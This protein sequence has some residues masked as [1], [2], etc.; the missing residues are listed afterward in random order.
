MTAKWINLLIFFFLA[1]GLYAQYSS[2]SPM[3]EAVSNNAVVEDEVDGKMY[4]Y[5]FCGI[6]STKIW[7]GIH[8]KAW[9]LDVEANE[10]TQLPDVPDSNG[11]KIAAAASY[12]NGKIY[13]IGGYHVAQSGNEISSDKVHVFDP[14]TNAWMQDAASIPVPVDDHV[15]G[16][17]KDS[18]IYV[19]TGWSNSTNVVNVQIFNPINNSWSAG[20]PVPNQNDYRVF[21][22]SG[23][24]IGDT[25]YYAGGARTTIN[26]SPSSIFRKGAINPLNPNEIDW[27][28]ESASEAK[29]YRMASST[30]NDRAIWLGGSDITYNY[31]GIAYNG[32]GGVPPL[33]RITVYD[34]ASG[35]LF[36]NFGSMP[37]I[38][39]L[40][41]AAKINENEIVIAGGMA[42]NQK[43]TDEVWRIS[44]DNLTSTNPESI[45]PAEISVFPN[46]VSDHI[47]IE[48]DGWFEFE[49]VS[50]DGQKIM[51]GNGNN[52][53]RINL[54]TLESGVYF[55]F[56]KNEDNIT[57]I[58]KLIIQSH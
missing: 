39:D 35:I 1:N 57:S 31:N 25:I 36:Q 50:L 13:L 19:V 40:R 48:M 53:K 15:Q 24:I 8:L 38:M 52:Y 43:V 49:L 46:P 16:I 17:W 41:G 30:H 10:W 37:A 7:S 5:S 32:S 20:T 44:L 47:F 4:V 55:L 26:F 14:G 21:G 18:L 2:L 42:A 6:D 23:V 9:R 34:P 56:M 28:K 3:P 22:G 29:G 58:E 54:P 51:Q 12:I 27:S 33:D 11:G 45:E